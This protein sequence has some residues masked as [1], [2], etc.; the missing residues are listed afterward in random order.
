MA[1]LRQREEDEERG[2]GSGDAEERK[3]NVGGRVRLKPVRSS[4]NSPSQGLHEAFEMQNSKRVCSAAALFRF[5]VASD[6]LARR[7]P[8]M[9]TSSV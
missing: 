6:T 3:T 2:R 1:R 9:L 5:A 7:S 4:D 8:C